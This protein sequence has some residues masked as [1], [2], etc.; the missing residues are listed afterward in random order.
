MRR[1]DGK[2]NFDERPNLQLCETGADNWRN[3]KGP[4]RLNPFLN[5]ANFIASDGAADV[6]LITAFVIREIKQL[7]TV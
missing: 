7:S 3:K 5:E 6:G 4:G 2:L 1:V